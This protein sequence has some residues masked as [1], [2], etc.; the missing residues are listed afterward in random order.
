VVALF[1]GDWLRSGS[2]DNAGPTLRV[3]VL[4]L[5]AGGVCVGVRWHDAGPLLWALACLAAGTFVGFLFGVP[6]ISQEEA[7][8]MAKGTAYRQ[9]VN[10]NL[11]QISDWLTKIVVGLGLVNLGEIPALLWRAGYRV[12]ASIEGT[13][14]AISL[15]IALV[16]Y[17]T[18]LGFF[19]GYLLTRLYLAAVFSKADQAAA[20]F[21]RELD[22]L[23][24]KVTE[25]E[26]VGAATSEETLAAPTV[27]AV[28][29]EVAAP[30]A[31]ERSA[32]KL[33]VDW[34]RYLREFE[35]ITQATLSEREKIVLLSVLIEQMIREAARGAGISSAERGSPVRLA[36]TLQDKG[37]ISLN[38]LGAFLQFWELRNTAIH[39]HFELVQSQAA[40]MLD[41]AWRLVRLFAGT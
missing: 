41:L 20:A 36:R 15:G 10:T 1:R 37:L 30:A 35:R 33:K 27:S 4:L 9:R 18:V 17:F 31:D 34:E 16:I 6:R 19:L 7:S 40:R 14:P 23:E 22:A 38:Q 12:A 13:P 32:S 8:T 24:D 28:V 2:D 39:G 29:G 25:S 5:I 26:V 11:E 21:G 3:I